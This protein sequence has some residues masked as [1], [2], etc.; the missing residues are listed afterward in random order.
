M[1]NACGLRRPRGIRVPGSTEVVVQ[2]SGPSTAN[3]YVTYACFVVPGRLYRI[4]NQRLRF[5]KTAPF[6][7]PL[8][9]RPVDDSCTDSSGTSQPMVPRRFGINY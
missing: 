9:A 4:E 7:P 5:R 2:V 1:T 6:A 3:K 8:P